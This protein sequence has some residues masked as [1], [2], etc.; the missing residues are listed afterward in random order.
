M[1]AVWMNFMKLIILVVSDFF[2][3]Y[4]IKKEGSQDMTIV[5]NMKKLL[6]C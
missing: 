1:K 2:I 5:R 4:F 6:G 3:I